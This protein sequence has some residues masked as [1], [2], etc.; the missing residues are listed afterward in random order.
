MANNVRWSGLCRQEAPIAHA[1]CARHYAE[2]EQQWLKRTER[3]CREA[4]NWPGVPRRWLNQVLVLV[5]ILLRSLAPRSRSL[6]TQG[7]VLFRWLRSLLTLAAPLL[8]S[9][10]T[11]GQR[12]I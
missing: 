11:S 10:D 12:T 1:N 5:S 4:W 9:I 6:I 8:P 2:R 7:W 3:K